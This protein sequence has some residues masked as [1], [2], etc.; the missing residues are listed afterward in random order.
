MKE[1]AHWGI[2]FINN[3]DIEWVYD[4]FTFRCVRRTC[5]KLETKCLLDISGIFLSIKQTKQFTFRN[6]VTRRKLIQHSALT[7]VLDWSKMCN[8][9]F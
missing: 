3:S 4:K 5:E 2:F 6:K 1:M 8:K 9:T 7:Q